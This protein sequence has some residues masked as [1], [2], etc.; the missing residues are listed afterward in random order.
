MTQSKDTSAAQGACRN[1]LEFLG[2]NPAREGLLDTP[3][4]YV[5]ALSEMTQGYSETVDKAI[6]AGIFSETCSDMI[7]VRDIEFYSLCEHHILPFFGKVHIAYIPNGKILGLS[8]FPRLVNV[9][10]R[11]LQVQERL[12]QQ[13]TQAIF[14]KISPRGVAC[15]IESQHFCMMMRGVKTQQSKVLTQSFLG[16]FATEGQFRSEFLASINYDRK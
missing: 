1:I 4:R 2:E 15:V 9:F 5:K 12:T 8:K 13:I 6:G 16:E 7:L 10:A 3:R 11:R 14:E